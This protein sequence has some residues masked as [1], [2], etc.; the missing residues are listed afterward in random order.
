LID[1]RLHIHHFSYHNLQVSHIGKDDIEADAST[2]SLNISLLNGLNGLMSDHQ[3][4]LSQYFTTCRF[5]L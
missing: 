1:V 2:Q 5:Q 4:Q 3:F